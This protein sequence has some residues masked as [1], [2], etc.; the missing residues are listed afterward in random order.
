M[1]AIWSEEEL[2]AIEWEEDYGAIWESR[3]LPVDLLISPEARS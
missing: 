1:S 2:G 3:R